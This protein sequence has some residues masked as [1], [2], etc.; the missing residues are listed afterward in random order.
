MYP[1]SIIMAG[2]TQQLIGARGDDPV[3]LPAEPKPARHRTRHGAAAGLRFVADRL[4]R[5]DRISPVQPE[6]ASVR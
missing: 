2:V 5:L 4:D 6:P 3:V 1:A